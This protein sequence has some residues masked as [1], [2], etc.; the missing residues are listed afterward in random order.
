MPRICF[1][2]CVVNGSPIREFTH[3]KGLRQG[4]PFA[5]FLFLIVAEGLAGV[6][7]MAEEKSLIESLV[8]G[9]AKVK[10]N[11]LQYVDDTL[12]FCEANTKSVFNIKG[13]LLCFELASG[14]KV[15]FLKSRIGVLGLGQ[16]SLQH[17]AA[18]LNCKVM[19]TPFVYLGLPVG[20]CHKR[21]AFW[22]GVIERVQGK[23][24]RWRGRCLSLAGRICLIKSV[25]SSIPLFFM[26]LFKLPSV[27]A[28]KLV[29]LQRNFLLGW[30]SDGRKIAWASWKKGL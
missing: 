8:V 18:I 7:R 2:L 14:L 28:K 20:G 23:L 16:S 1:S 22:S 21:D 11:M 27:M 9:R 6:F 10:V 3:R 5:P 15:N 17:F 29:R 24:S 26:S 19:V 25:Q 4:D 13:I 30:G 12:F